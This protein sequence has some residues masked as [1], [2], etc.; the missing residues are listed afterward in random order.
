MSLT[1][2]LLS[3][4]LCRTPNRLQWSNWLWFLARRW[5]KW[6]S[7]GLIRNTN[8][9]SAYKMEWYYTKCNYIDRLLCG[10]FHDDLCFSPLF[11]SAWQICSLLRGGIAER[12]GVRVGHRII[13]INGQ[14][15]VAV[16][17]E[18][19]VGLLATSVGEVICAR[20]DVPVWLFFNFIF[21]VPADQYED[22][23]HLH[24]S[25][26]D[27]P[28]N[29]CLHLMMH[30]GSRKQNCWLARVE[31]VSGSRAV[32]VLSFD[33]A[34]C[35]WCWYFSKIKSRNHMEGKGGKKGMGWMRASDT[36]YHVTSVLFSPLYIRITKKKRTW[37]FF[38]KSYFSMF[39]PLHKHPSFSFLLFL[40]LPSSRRRF[41][42][43]YA[44]FRSSS[45]LCKH[46]KSFI[47]SERRRR[48]TIYDYE[49]RK[50]LLEL[51]F[52]SFALFMKN[53]ISYHP[54][55]IFV[56]EVSAFCVCCF[57]FVGLSISVQYVVADEYKRN[58]S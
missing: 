15:V 27:W 47:R 55:L 7:N 34:I 31:K 1:P 40:S 52:F 37:F 17:H 10:T 11:P 35:C 3:L 21:Y 46:P 43:L 42:F 16:P 12:G 20:I 44:F 18:R 39:S 14:S 19:I 54:R 48:K 5:L 32:R 38:C 8:W 9:V 30:L 33:S 57:V 53:S 49:N 29:S 22:D 26:F 13:E 25:P 41:E 50:P 58:G 2:L 36:Y 23:A 6:R 24:V 56:M 51:V 28:G 4:L 45:L